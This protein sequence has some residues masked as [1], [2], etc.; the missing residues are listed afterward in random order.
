MDAIS[1]A[2]LIEHV[3]ADP[4]QGNLTGNLEDF[5]RL[6]SEDNL[7]RLQESHPGVF[8]FL[9]FHP[10][11]DGHV[12]DYVRSGTLV[13]DT[14][15]RVLAFFTLDEDAV[16]SPSSPA[17]DVI[18]VDGDVHIAYE[19]TSLLFSPQA[20]PPLPGVLFTGQLSGTSDAVYTPLGD[21]ADTN[22]VR[23]RLRAVFSLADQAWNAGRDRT[24]FADRFAKALVSEQIEYL[25]SGR[26]SMGEWVRKSYHRIVDH[27]LELMTV[28]GSVIGGQL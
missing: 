24:D 17:P 13:S 6:L 26:R 7:V 3:I 8:A 5:M 2:E 10:S 22:E 14:G 18:P 19:V 23:S 4:D 28:L 27:G 16:A 1:L 25:R 12:A 21:L 15:P 20:P 11:A 9:V